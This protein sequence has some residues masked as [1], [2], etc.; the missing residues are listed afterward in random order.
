MK[1]WKFAKLICNET[2]E[3]NDSLKSFFILLLYENLGLPFYLVS[4]QS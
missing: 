2:L 4:A 1:I 3:E